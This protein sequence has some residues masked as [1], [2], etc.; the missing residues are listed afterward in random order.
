MGTST[1]GSVSWQQN[2]TSL[3]IFL[4]PQSSQTTME[5]F[6]NMVVRLLCALC[7]FYNSLKTSV[8]ASL[9]K[10]NISPIVIKWSSLRN[11]TGVKPGNNCIQTDQCSFIFAP[12]WSYYIYVGL[13]KVRKI[14]IQGPNHD[15][16]PSGMKSTLF[17][18]FCPFCVKLDE[19]L[20]RH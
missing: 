20:Y 4:N 7:D 1:S 19:F 3:P 17:K 5:D 9:C 11:I 16:V 18:V 13:P 12:Q 10:K 6:L 15:P 14:Y 2:L 8:L